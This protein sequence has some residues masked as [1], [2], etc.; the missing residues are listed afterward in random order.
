[1][2]PKFKD[3][4][5]EEEGGKGRERVRGVARRVRKGGEKGGEG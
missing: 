5:N 4:Y 3:M 1:M 2:K